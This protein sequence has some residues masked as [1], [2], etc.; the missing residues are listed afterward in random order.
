MI[1]LPLKYKHEWLESNVD[2]FNKIDRD[3][4]AKAILYDNVE[5]G[6]IVSVDNSTDYPFAIVEPSIDI[7]FYFR[8][9]DLGVQGIDCIGNRKSITL[10]QIENENI[11][12]VVVWE[13]WGWG[14]T[15]EGASISCCPIKFQDILYMNERK[16]SL[17]LWDYMRTEWR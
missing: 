17:S 8:P 13:I 4:P 7:P 10:R 2:W 6:D 16:I 5:I 11:S 9:N 12:P 14:D 15:E 1:R 3:R